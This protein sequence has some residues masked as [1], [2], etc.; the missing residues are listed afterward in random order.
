[1][2]PVE[3][4]SR[5]REFVRQFSVMLANRV[6]A[7]SSLANL[8]RRRQIEVIGVSVQDSRDATVARLVLSDP[9]AAEEL[10]LEKG[11]AFTVSRLVVVRLRESGSGLTRCLATLH[12]GETNVDFAYSLLVQNQGQ[13]LL[14]MHLEDEEFGASILNQAGLT[15]V[16]EDELLR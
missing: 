12:E 3:G 16:Y 4:V 8:L 7:F 14:A 6:G 15:V 10:L 9:D 1:M 2:N 11:I 5:K 13:S